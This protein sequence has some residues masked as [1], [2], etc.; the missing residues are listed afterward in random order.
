MRPASQT[1][2]GLQ[3][4]YTTTLRAAC[5]KVVSSLPALLLPAEA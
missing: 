2:Y 4:S 5:Y 1:L 3:G